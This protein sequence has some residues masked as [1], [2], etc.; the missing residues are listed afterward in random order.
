MKAASL[1]FIVAITASSIAAHDA[2]AQTRSPSD[3][4]PP[5]GG[6]WKAQRQGCEGYVTTD[7]HIATTFTIS[8]EQV[9]FRRGPNCQYQNTHGSRGARW[10]NVR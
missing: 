9:V 4:S 8:G 6:W 3:P 10:I 7:A 2:T 5:A 1:I